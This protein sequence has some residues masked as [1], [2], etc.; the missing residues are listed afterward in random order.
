[1]K[2]IEMEYALFRWLMNNNKL[3]M[4][5]YTAGIKGLNHECD[6]LAVS[7]S[8][9]LTEYEIKVSKSDLK[10]DFKKKHKHESDRLKYQYFAIP[11]EMRDCVDIIPNKFGVVIITERRDRQGKDYYSIKEIREPYKNK[12]AS[13]I[14][15]SEFINLCRIQALKLWNKVRSEIIK[16]C[17]KDLNY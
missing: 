11:K 5:R 13:K 1:M 2:T 16:T 10:A 9:Y 15:D 3:I 4:P 6:I 8:G 12:N 14:T 17:G 7:K